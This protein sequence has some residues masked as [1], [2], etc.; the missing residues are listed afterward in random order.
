M[1]PA[2]ALQWPMLLDMTKEECQRVLRRLGEYT[3]LTA[4]N[5][6]MTMSNDNLTMSLLVLTHQKAG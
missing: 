3:D 6:T 4:C 2:E 5:Y 1:L